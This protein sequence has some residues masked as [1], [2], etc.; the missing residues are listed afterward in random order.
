MVL[1]GTPPARSS[2]RATHGGMQHP[3]GGRR[4]PAQSPDTPWCRHRPARLDMAECERGGQDPG[5]QGSAEE[6]GSA[7][8]AGCVEDGAGDWRCGQAARHRSLFYPPL[9]EKTVA[10]ATAGSWSRHG[11]WS[12]MRRNISPAG[13]TCASILPWCNSGGQGAPP[14][15][16]ATPPPCRFIAGGRLWRSVPLPTVALAGPSPMPASSIAA[17]SGHGA[18]GGGRP[19]PAPRQQK[20]APRVS[21]GTA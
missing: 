21:T 3:R 15:R 14:G 5:E 2:A 10:H 18:R 12:L 16:G 11:R 4:R 13:G 20:C 6:D 8:T 19:P 7:G 17:C 1:R 9:Q